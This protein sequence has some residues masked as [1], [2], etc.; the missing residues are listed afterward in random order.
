MQQSTS[1]C[2]FSVFDHSVCLISISNSSVLHTEQWFASRL[3]VTGPTRVERSMLLLYSLYFSSVSQLERVTLDWIFAQGQN[4]T[5]VIE[6]QLQNSP[7]HIPRVLI[8]RSI[9]RHQKTN[10]TLTGGTETAVFPV[11]CRCR[12]ETSTEPVSRCLLRLCWEQNVPQS[13]SPP[14][15]ISMSP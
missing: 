1:V 7:A 11:M 10:V 9:S 5:G 14:V 13:K 2:S 4:C 6:L 8:H 12:P 15:V 3:F